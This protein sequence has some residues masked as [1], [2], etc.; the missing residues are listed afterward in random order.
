MFNFFERKVAF[1]YLRARRQEGFI[2]VIAG[3][4]FLGIT[5]GVATLIIVMAVM[6]GFREKLLS[7]MIGF[8]GHMGIYAVSPKGLMDYQDLIGLLKTIPGIKS[9]NPMVERQAMV[10]QKGQA[11]G[12]MAYGIRQE[13]LEA[14]RLIS[15]NIIFGTLDQFNRENAIVIGKRMAEKFHVM[16]GDTLMLVSPQGTATAFGTVPR[17]RQFSVAAIFEVGMYLYDSNAVFIPMAT[18][19]KFFQLGKAVTNIELFIDN[20]D[21]VDL[22]RERIDP[23]IGNG[24]RVQDWQEAN[25]P[26]FTALEVERNVMFIILTLIIVIASFN[27]ISSLIMLVKDKSRDIAIMRTMGAT[28]GMILRIFFLSGASIGVAG[29]LGG[30][31]LGLLFALNIETIRGLIQKLT[32]AELFSA[33]IYFLSQLPARV[34]AGEVA[35]VV[36]M[37]LALSF[38]ATLYPAWR[39]ARL[40]PVEAL[41]YE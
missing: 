35:G 25:A 32:G 1:R 15:S 3:F 39:A 18:A 13:D 40:D 24:L 16:P 10:I 6:N 23:Y 26:Y 12:A 22:I 17:M 38:L 29:T 41:R 14:R 33:E 5:L 7:Q 9:L 21:H 36:L 19:Q 30:V 2:S 27:I 28:R 31:A 8:N 4:S 20:P 37:S 34:D 11:A